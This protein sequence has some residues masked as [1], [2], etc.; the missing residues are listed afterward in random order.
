MQLCFS[1]W[2]WREGGQAETAGMDG[3]AVWGE[4]RRERQERTDPDDQPFIGALP[5]DP[6][7]DIDA[8]ELV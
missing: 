3:A 8:I 5:K 1:W 4:G 7:L 6:G 2:L